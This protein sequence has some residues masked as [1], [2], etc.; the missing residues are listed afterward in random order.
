MDDISW[1]VVDVIVTEWNPSV[2]NTLTNK[3]VQLAIIYPY[4]TLEN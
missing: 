4:G 2:S 3:L 1:Q